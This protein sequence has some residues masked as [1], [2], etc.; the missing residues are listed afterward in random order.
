MNGQKFVRLGKNI[1]PVFDMARDRALVCLAQD[2]HAPD[3]IT[4]QGYGPPPEITIRL[5]EL[6]LGPLGR[7]RQAA[8]EPLCRRRPYRL[9]KSMT[10]RSKRRGANAVS[11]DLGGGAGKQRFLPGL[12]AMK[13]RSPS[14]DPVCGCY[15]AY[16]STTLPGV[17]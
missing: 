11:L 13:A 4:R 6:C 3:E 15:L 9:P 8:T 2:R 5:V 1:A 7:L 16:N 14:P 12:Q 17:A 10:R